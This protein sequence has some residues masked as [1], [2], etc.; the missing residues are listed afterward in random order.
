M[1]G[2]GGVGRSLID[3]VRLLLLFHRSC[4]WLLVS[5]TDDL[6]LV[7]LTLSS[8]HLDGHVLSNFEEFECF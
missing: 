5:F 8:L 3:G 7:W 2:V 6:E 4:E 1:R